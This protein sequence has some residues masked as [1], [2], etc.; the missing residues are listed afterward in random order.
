MTAELHTLTGAYALDAVSDVERAEF[1]R[2]LGECP[3]CRQEVEELRATGAR[4][5]AAEA[6]EPP[7][8]LRARVLA[9]VTRTRQLPPRVTAAV[10]PGRARTWQVRA[11]LF[12]AAAAAVVAVVLGV[13]TAASDRQLDA[14]QQE[15]TSLNSVL[16]AP[17]ASTLKGSGLAGATLVVS[18]EQ[19]KAVLLASGF[20]ALDKG[21][22]YQVWFT[23]ADGTRSAG[24][25]QP[26]SP[27]QMRPMLAAIPP[28]T[29]HI[30]ITVEPA[31]GSA[32]PSTAPVSTIS[33]T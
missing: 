27:H 16:T 13:H 22:T 8:E 12:G 11:A 30:G 31:G 4:L 32:A 17:D 9:E 29:D 33:L 3:A 10:A 1:E 19:G 7:A 26:E 2:H 25:M 24:L 23:G 20:P 15:Q 28:G 14:A 6:V 21:H 5:A 18:R